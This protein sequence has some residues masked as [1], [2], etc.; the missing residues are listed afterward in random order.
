MEY[1][2]IPADFMVESV[3]SNM[4]YAIGDWGIAQLAKKLGKDEDYKYF[5]KRSKLYR[6]YFDQETKFMRGKLSD[7]SWRPRY[8]PDSAQ[9]RVNDDCEGNAW[10]FLW[11]LPQYPERLIDILR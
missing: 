6:E 9:H 11:L 8:D 5:K 10:P 4:E 1:G 2:Y 7:G 3:A